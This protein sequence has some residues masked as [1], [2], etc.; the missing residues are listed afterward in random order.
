MLTKRSWGTAFNFSHHINELSFGPYFPNLH[1]P[2][3]AAHATTPGHFHK[4]QYFLSV[5]PTIYTDSPSTLLTSTPPSSAQKRSQTHDTQNPSPNEPDAKKNPGGGE[6]RFV[7]SVLAGSPRTVYTNQYA[8]TEHS[9]PVSE[10]AVPG[11]FFKYDIEPILLTV[12]EEWGGVLGLIVRCVN[13]VAGVMVAGGWVVA[14]MEW[15]KEVVGAR[16]RRRSSA[17]GGLLFGKKEHE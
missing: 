10:D 16:R 4:Y 5:V 11:I 14:L 3:D 17:A 9:H 2:L 15:A 13:V 7:P 1:N 12:A 6:R 8:V